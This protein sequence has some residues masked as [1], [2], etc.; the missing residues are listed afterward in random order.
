[1][2]CSDAIEA[3]IAALIV[4]SWFVK[5]AVTTQKA[6]KLHRL[7]PIS[8]VAEFIETD[9]EKCRPLSSFTS[10]FIWTAISLLVSIVSMFFWPIVFGVAVLWIFYKICKRMS[11]F[12]K[13]VK[14][15]VNNLDDFTIDDLDNL[16]EDYGY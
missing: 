10:F 5:T 13:P 14:S 7:K 12:N 8:F 15:V 16:N 4:L 11:D 9:I 6:E 3:I 2:Y 1:M